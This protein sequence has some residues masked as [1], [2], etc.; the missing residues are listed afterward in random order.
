MSILLFLFTPV[1]LAIYWI[2]RLQISLSRVRYLVD[3]YGLSRKKLRSLKYKELRILQ[4][5]AESL[6]ISN[7]AYALEALIKP[8]RA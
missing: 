5:Q 4:E 1:L 3:T 8:Y 2:V 6:R 7:D